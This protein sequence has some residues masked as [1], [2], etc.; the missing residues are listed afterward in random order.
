V[1]WVPALAMLVFAAVTGALAMTRLR[2]LA[3]V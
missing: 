3:E 1:V 2:R